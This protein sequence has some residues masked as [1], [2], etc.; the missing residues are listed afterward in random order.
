MINCLFAVG[1]MNKNINDM[2]WKERVIFVMNENKWYSRKQ[3]KNAL[4][5]DHKKDRNKTRALSYY[6]LKLVQSGHIERAYA[7]ELIKIDPLDHVKYV[8]R[9]TNKPYVRS[10]KSLLLFK[11]GNN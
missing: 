10:E 7:P 11:R 1:N 6:I 3:I 8:Y 9:R 2:T 4:G 5:L